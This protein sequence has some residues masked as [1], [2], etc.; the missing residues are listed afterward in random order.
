MVSL[1]EGVKEKQSFE[2]CLWL[3]LLERLFSGQ[4]DRNFKNFIITDPFSCKYGQVHHNLFNAAKYIC[5]MIV[6]CLRLC[7]GFDSKIRPTCF[8]QYDCLV[9][10]VY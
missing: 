10:S 6:V 1:L 4:M 2:R 5:L 9:I 7:C 8:R 3:H